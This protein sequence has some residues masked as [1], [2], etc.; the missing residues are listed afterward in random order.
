MRTLLLL[1]V[2]VCGIFGQSKYFIGQ[3]GQS[4]NEVCFNQAMNCNPAIKTNN[5]TALFTQLGVTCTPDAAPWWAEDQPAYISD[6]NDPN[7]GKCLGYTGVPSGVL[8]SGSYPA[9]NRLCLCDAPSK[10]AATFGTAL[11]GFGLPVSETWVFS[12]FVAPGDFGV[13]QHFWTTAPNPTENDV[14]IRYY[15][16]GEKNAS[17]AFQPS[18]ACGV[19]FGDTQA[20]W[21]TKWF[22]KGAADGGYFWNFRVPFQKSIIVTA[23][24]TVKPNGGFYMIVRGSTNSQIVIGDYRVPTT[25]KLLQFT[26]N[27]A[28]NAL[29]F[30]PIAALSSGAGIF[31]MHTIAVRSGNMNFL[32]GCYHLMYP[33]QDFPGT[34]LSSGTEDYF[35]SGWYFNAGQFHLPVSGFTHLNT[36]DGVSWSAYRFHEMDPIVFTNGFQMLW[37]NGDM[38]DPAGI[39]CLIKDGG[40]IVGTPT[41]SEVQ[42]YAWVYTW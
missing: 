12:W 40:R 28:F 27:A 10:S 31:F 26:N 2:F 39:K 24:H 14:I 11:A 37:R 23:E 41:V 29:D 15:V 34:L 22:G 38:L 6:H 21:G 33:G 1:V 5:S 25:A 17:I 7:Y 19:G 16:D 13:M 42:T 20:P 8:C 4:C 32:E 36:S 35:D 30:V 18:L 3:M 9:S